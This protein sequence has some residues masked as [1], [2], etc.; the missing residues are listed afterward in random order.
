M[1]VDIKI[2][3]RFVIEGLLDQ[4]ILRTISK[5]NRAKLV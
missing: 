2:G 3:V 4:R 5:H 1:E